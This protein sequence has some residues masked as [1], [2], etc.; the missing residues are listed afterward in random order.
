MF[1]FRES[2]TFEES[3]EMKLTVKHDGRGQQEILCA[4]TTMKMADGN[5][6][7]GIEVRIEVKPAVWWSETLRREDFQGTW[8]QMGKGYEDA[9][10]LSFTRAKN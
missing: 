8:T 1:A 2:L 7:L 6:L 10:N 9:C 3:G 5:K 4:G